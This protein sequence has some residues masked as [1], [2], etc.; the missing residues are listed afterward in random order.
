[1]IQ[2]LRILALVGGV[3]AFAVGQLVTPVYRAVPE[4]LIQPLS[5]LIPPGAG[6]AAVMGALGFLIAW[7]LESLFYLIVLRFS[8]RK[9]FCDS[10]ASYAPLTALLVYS[11]L[12]LPGMP[13]VSMLGWWLLLDGS[14][15]VLTV[16]GAAVVYRKSAVLLPHLGGFYPVRRLARGPLGTILYGVG[17]L[18]VLFALTPE[19][20]F[21]EP[22]DERWGTGDEPRYV[23]I[24]AS[25]LYDGDANISN[26]AEHIGR[27]AE[28]LRFGSYVVSWTASTFSTI[29]DVAASA[30]GESLGEPESLGGQVIRGK[31]GGTYYVYLPGFP[32]LIVPSMALDSVF[33]PGML[34]LVIFFCLVVGVMT[35]IVIARLIEPYVGDRFD[36]YLL[37]GCLSLTPP[38]FFYNFQVYPEMAGAFCLAV[39]LKLLLGRKVGFG[40]AVLFG[41]AAATLPWLHTRYYPILGVS[42]LAMVYEMW[43]GRVSWKVGLWAIG[44]PIVAV[45]LQCLYVFHIG[46]SLLPDTLWVVNGY[47]RG[48]HFFN[49][50]ALSGVYYL[51]FGREEGL[52][53]YSPLYMLAI[54]GAVSLWRR[55]GFAAVLSIA[56]FAPYLMIAASHD[57]GGAGAWA[58]TSRYLIPMTPV[59]ALWLAAWLDVPGVRRVR[60]MAFALGA[61]ASFWIGQGMLVE[62]NFPYDRIAFLSSGVVNVS[63]LLGS[64]LEPESFWQRGAYPLLLLLV[65]AAV[66]MWGWNKKARFDGLATSIVALILMAGSV[67][68][69]R[70]P[71]EA[72][73]SPAR[74]T[75]SAQLRPGRTVVSVLPSCS[76]GLPRL[77]FKGAGGEY[78]VTVRGHGLTRHLRVPPTGTTELDISVEPFVRKRRGEKEDLRKEIR[79]IELS[80][81]AGHS[82]LVFQV[83]CR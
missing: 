81:A 68:E 15:W 62:R 56:V 71:S 30:M 49:R 66:A 19:R 9:A 4:M 80:L 75:S 69:A 11:L 42:V 31:A 41:L 1:M 63:G 6:T 45:A 48:A 61:A 29:K 64:V 3:S 74:G 57:Q 55:S 27:R 2:S 78:A 5:V 23:R 22:Y 40:G 47:P 20:R 28:P 24:T 12:L 13:G 54:P 83:V 37:I 51:L 60:W 79:I 65:L 59:L 8:W 53:V 36:A 52:F 82:P 67:S 38:L 18:A 76:V 58:P 50:E 46:G 72:W 7:F 14:P 44:L 73:T 35:A 26:A 34:P 17:L 16:I 70:M 77:R 25:L 21:S 33:F 10:L 32:F 39:I 43:G